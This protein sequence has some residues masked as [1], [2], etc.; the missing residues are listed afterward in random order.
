MNIQTTTRPAQQSAA[1]NI[2]STAAQATEEKPAAETAAAPQESFTP[3]AEND[4]RGSA[5]L[6]GAIRK[7][8]AWGDV[9]EKPLGGMAALGLAIGG[10]LAL[11]LGGAMVGGIVGGSFGSAV[12]TLQADGPISFLGHA[13]SNMGSAISV[14]STIGSVAGIVGGGA[15]GLKVGS[16]IARTAAFVPGAIV[17]G[18]Q[19]AANPGSVPPAEKKDPKDPGHQQELHGVFKAGAKLGGG[20][21]ILSGAAGGFVTGATLT[22]A[23]ALV[24]DVA[25]GDFTMKN[26][27]S[28]LGTT[29]LIGG[30]IGALAGGT[31]GGMGGEMAFGKAP[32]WVWDKTAGRFTA[33]QPGV[34]ERIAKREAEL[35]ERQ[36]KLQGETDNLSRE[37]QTYRDSHKASSDSLTTREDQMASDETR[38]SSELG[39]VEGRIE[40]NAQ[41][42][43]DKRSA[44]A[45]PAL[46]A[47]GNHGVIG[48]RQSLNTWD[49]KLKGWEGDLNNFRSEL[50]GWEK[51]LDNKIDVEAGKIFADERQPIDK[52]FSEMHAK[53]DEY[54][55]KL[56]KYEADINGRIQAKYESGINA[57]KPGVVSDLNAARSE[58]QRSESE[59][60]DARSQRAQAQS[61]VDSAER[62]RDGARSRLR[63]A[64][65]E[66]SSLR[67]RISS[68]Q[69]RISSLQSQISSCRSGF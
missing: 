34:Q 60:S 12:A 46:D 40:Q 52:Q 5:M 33:N 65:S 23:G 57:E 67:S 59:L 36:E 41:A 10:G 48:E 15:L 50:I 63:N 24:T 9:A 20:I 58:K 6:R 3:A 35:T 37:T 61:R 2:K 49:S 62:S 31:I 25:Q 66:E 19:G 53:L 11:S 30:G 17:G 68:L 43:Y 26:F 44:T 1:P 21:G 54:E 32:Q 4:S 42:D 45:D 47:K 64:E 18:I 22:A 16:N 28:Q 29:A 8:V 51:K 55:Q 38:V 13:F 7:G 69:S 27:V 56:N 39:T 14:G